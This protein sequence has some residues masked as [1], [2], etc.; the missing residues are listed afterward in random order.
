M[1]VLT[2]GRLIN[3]TGAAPIEGATIVLRDNRIEA[4]TTRNRSDWPA[5][6]EVI[7]VSRIPVL[8]VLMVSHAPM[9]TPRSSLEQRGRPEE[10]Q[11]TRHLRTAAV[12]KQTLAA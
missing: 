3:G 2:G 10:P 11:S 5:D 12:L 4:V 1:K 8:P 7:D 6:A 9:P